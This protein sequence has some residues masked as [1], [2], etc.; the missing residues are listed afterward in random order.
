MASGQIT[1]AVVR[2]HAAGDV[3]VADEPVPV[4]R[5]GEN[6]VRVEAVGLCGS[7]LHWYVAFE[8]AGADAAVAQAADAFAVAAARTGLKV[9]VEPQGAVDRG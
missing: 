5:G 7:D 9:L 8:V 3:R 2:L 6:L 1:A 4:P